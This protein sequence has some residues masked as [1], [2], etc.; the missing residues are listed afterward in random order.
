MGTVVG[1][2][3]QTL[4]VVDLNVDIGFFTGTVLEL[5]TY[6]P[7]PGSYYSS[8]ILWLNLSHPFTKDVVPYE[9]LNLLLGAFS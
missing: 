8:I 5:S 3:C 6:D 2:W 4:L 7:G 9:Y 1:S